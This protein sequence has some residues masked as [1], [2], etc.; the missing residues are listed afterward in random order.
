MMKSIL[1]V[2]PYIKHIHFANPTGR[3]YPIEA[4]DGYI[5]FINLLKGVGYEDRISIE[6]YTKDF[7]HDA[8]RSV[9]ILRQLAN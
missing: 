3:V 9:K 7:R 6:A 4:E 2:G 8:K 5:R 1:D